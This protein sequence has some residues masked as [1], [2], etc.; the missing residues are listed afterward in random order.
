MSRLQT[1]GART[2]QLYTRAFWVDA[3]LAFSLTL[4]AGQV[5][6]D[7]SPWRLTFNVT[8]SIPLGIYA[9]KLRTPGSALAMGQIACFKYEAPGPL[10][11]RHY[12]K[13]GTTL[14]KPVAAVAG[15]LAYQENAHLYI[16]DP[17]AQTTKKVTAVAQKDKAGRPVPAYFDTTPRPVPDGSYLLVAPAKPNSFDSRYLGPIADHKL[18]QTAIPLIT[19]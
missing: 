10:A 8:P 15:M 19:W 16:V 18:F 9:T 14:C 2:R 5:L 12:F 4:L 13:E 1:L 11:Q 17:I 3:F 6:T 7:Y